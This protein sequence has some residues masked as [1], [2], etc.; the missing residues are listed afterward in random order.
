[1]KTYRGKIT[2]AAI[3]LLLAAVTGFVGSMAADAM[4][5]T[6]KRPVLVVTQPDLA[7][8]TYTY[9]ILFAKGTGLPVTASTGLPTA[10]TT[11]ALAGNFFTKD[12]VFSKWDIKFNTALPAGTYIMQTYGSTDTTADSADTIIDG[13][14]FEFDWNGQA[15]IGD[16]RY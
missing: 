4:A 10:G 16:L 8:Y 5:A 15:I 7:L 9:Y 11:W 6:T 2:V 13:M 14:S 12:S 1:M 3:V